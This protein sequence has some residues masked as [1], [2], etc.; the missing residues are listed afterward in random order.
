MES[1]PWAHLSRCSGR[2]PG[3]GM[4]SM[5][6]GIDPTDRQEILPEPSVGILPISMRYCG[7]FF[8]DFI[9]QLQIWHMHLMVAMQS[10][11]GLHTLVKSV[12]SFLSQGDVTAI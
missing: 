5:N 4:P 10:V 9:P 11:G 3:N 7:N 6:S 12:L 8:A 2:L 1:S